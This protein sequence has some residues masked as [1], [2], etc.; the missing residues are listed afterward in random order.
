MRLQRSSPFFNG[1]WKRPRPPGPTGQQYDGL[2]PGFGHI[3]RGI[4]KTRSLRSCR[5][6]AVI[7]VAS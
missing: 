6:P 5:I 1:W 7:Q 4:Q 2:P 3:S